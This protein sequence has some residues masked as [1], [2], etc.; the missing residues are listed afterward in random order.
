MTRDATGEENLAARM[1]CLI[2]PTHVEEKAQDTGGL[3]SPVTATD[4][5]PSVEEPKECLSAE[6]TTPGTNLRWP[7]GSDKKEPA[8][9]S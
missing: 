7:V 4:D 8:R 6:T 1:N 5:C 2:A 3:L 9:S